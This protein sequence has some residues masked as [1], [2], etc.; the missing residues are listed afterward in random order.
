MSVGENP[1]TE[2]DPNTE[3]DEEQGEKVVDEEQGEKYD[4]GEIPRVDSSPE[5]PVPEQPPAS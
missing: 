3:V 4:G 5:Q 1:P 2:P